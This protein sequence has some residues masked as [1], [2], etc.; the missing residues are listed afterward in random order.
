MAE[1]A[2]VTGGAGG[3]GSSICAALAEDGIQVVVAD[4]RK[5]DAEA[6]AAKLKS[7]GKEALGVGVDVGDKQ[8]V[9]A[10]VQS[11]MDAYGQ[12]DHQINFAGLMSRFPIAEM[13]VEEW[14]RVIRVNL[15]GVFLC[16]QAAAAAMRPRKSGRIINVASGRGIAG[17]PQSAH[18]A[19]S[20]GGVIA[21]TK[22]MAVEVAPD[23][24]LVNNIC[25]GRTGT[26]MAR[27]GYTEEQW[28]AIEA[29]DP[30]QG[31]LTQKDEIAGLVRYLVSDATRFVTGQTFLL[32]TP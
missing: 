30:M 8:S 7:E 10:M 9:A 4:F 2:I 1:V 24:I 13:A 17:A 20:K 23:N 11:A 21:F 16:S 25:P 27:A 14:D 29:M 28:Q 19:A 18:Y 15:R 3:L 12:L 26:P 6:L 31:G 22:S 32:R 5:D